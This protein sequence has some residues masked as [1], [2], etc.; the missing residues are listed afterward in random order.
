MCFDGSTSD[1]SM[2]VYCDGCGMSVHM[3]CYGVQNHEDDF[4]CD[5][6]AKLRELEAES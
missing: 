5:R 4:C 6:C 2:I 3:E 1:D